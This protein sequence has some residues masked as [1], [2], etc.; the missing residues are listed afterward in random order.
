MIIHCTGSKG[1]IGKAFCEEMKTA[2]HQ[3]IEC[4]LPDKD[5][6]DPFHLLDIDNADIVVHVAAMADLNDCKA[7]MKDNFETNIAG[8]FNIA[9]VCR[10]YNKPLIFISTCCYYGNILDDIA[11]E[12]K[13]APMCF[14]PYATSKVAGEAIV[15]GMP[16]L[17]WMI[18]RFGTVY[19]VGM[20]PALFTYIAL[21]NIMD[22]NL[23]YIDGDG[24]QTRQ[25]IYLPDLVEA[26]KLSVD[27]FKSNEILNICG[28]API[29]VNDVIEI[30]EVIVGKKAD[31]RNREDR[32][33]QTLRENISIE[34]AEKVIGWKPKTKFANGMIDT[35]NKDIRFKKVNIVIPKKHRAV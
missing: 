18:L 4:D 30:S 34:R 8:T 35:Y 17:E 27:N 2:G 31:T 20:R 7:N 13:T 28:D 3:I 10:M 25:F 16:G 19:G 33:G 5:I 9:D 1:F 24:E 22:N 6:R 12:F 21:K 23:F 26:M 11:V 15:R 14:E 32:Y 29:S